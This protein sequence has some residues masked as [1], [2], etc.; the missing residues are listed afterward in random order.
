MNA[1]GV[2]S[3]AQY[4]S[5]CRTASVSIAVSLGSALSSNH[6][7]LFQYS[8]LSNPASGRS[9]AERVQ[10]IVSSSTAITNIECSG[11]HFLIDFGLP[12][13]TMARSVAGCAQLLASGN[14]EGS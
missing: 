14:G 5:L 4:L 13:G 1:K 8:F 11:L 7:E 3:Q 12:R 10:S 9:P 2:V 6:Q